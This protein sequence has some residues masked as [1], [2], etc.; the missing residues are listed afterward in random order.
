MIIVVLGL[1]GLFWWLVQGV[2]IPVL[3]PSG[4]VADQQHK[5]LVFTVLLSAVVVIPV[6]TLLVVFVWKYRETNKNSKYIPEWSENARLEYIWW[7][8]PIAI[9]LVLSIVTYRTSHSLDPYRPIASDRQTLEVQ[10]VALQWKW[11]FIYPEHKLAAVNQLTVPVDR[12]VHFTLSADA[13]MSAFWIPALGSQIYTMNSMSSQLNLMATERGTYRGYNTNINGSGYADMW[14]DVDV[15]SDEEFD[16]WMTDKL[17]SDDL[18]DQASLVKLAEP[19]VSD[20]R[21]YRLADKSLYQSIVM[22]NMNSMDSANKISHDGNMHSE[23][24]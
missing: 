13:P 21:Y 1:I 18:L 17:R 24:H 19:S 8:I 6:F 10:V 7:G 20:K 3:D 5:L 22:K 23:E 16:N 15:I 12:P 9:I 14:F 4:I 11:L 2:D